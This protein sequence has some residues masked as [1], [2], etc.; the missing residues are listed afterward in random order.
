LFFCIP[1]CFALKHLSLGDIVC[2][3]DNNTLCS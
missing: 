2:I 3:F 1:T